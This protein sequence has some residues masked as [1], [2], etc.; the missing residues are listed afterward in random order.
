MSLIP[1]NIIM[2]TTPW[3]VNKKNISDQYIAGFLDGDGSIGVHIEKRPDRR[4]FPFRVRI[5]IN[6]SQHQRHKNLLF[7]IQAA[8]D[9]VGSVRDIRSHNLSEL[10]IQKRSDIKII[11]ER[12]LPHL[13]LKQRQ[14]RI[15]LAMIKIFDEG[16]V[17][18][19]SSLSDKDYEK[20]FSMAKEI[21]NLNSGA[22]GKKSYEIIN[23][24]TT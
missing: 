13:I 12:L 22:G 11:I 20:L 18:I 5:K 19:R 2:K 17:N 10:V 4:R 8:L 6:F 21:R 3:E 1:Y 23:P 24:V 7:L 14:A 9:K 15:V 16:I